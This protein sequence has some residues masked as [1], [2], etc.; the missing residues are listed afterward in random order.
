LR[1]HVIDFVSVF[2][3]NADVFPVFNVADSAITCGG[4]LIVLLALLGR[5]YDGRSTRVS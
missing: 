4:V 3:P 2:A 5:D 1:G